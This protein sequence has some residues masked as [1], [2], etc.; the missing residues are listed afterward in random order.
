[1]Q[2][3]EFIGTTRHDVPVAD[4]SVLTQSI[5]YQGGVVAGDHG[6]LIGR[7]MF[8]CALRCTC[9]LLRCKNH[10]SQRN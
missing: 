8:D 2:I 7:L 5:R 1:M 4:V 9:T 6:A 10:L 3:E